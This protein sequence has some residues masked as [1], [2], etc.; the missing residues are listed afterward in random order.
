MI[1]W[2]SIKD[3]LPEHMEHVI[4]YTGKI[5]HITM[6][7]DMK[8]VREELAKKG[9]PCKDQETLYDFASIEVQGNCLDR[10]SHWMPIP[11]PP[12]TNTND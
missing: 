2:I 9:I 4:A 8:I 10:V 1:K 6:F 7:I 11:K 12:R 5:Q 3:R